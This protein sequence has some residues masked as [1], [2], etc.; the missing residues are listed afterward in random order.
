MKD[1]LNLKKN[2][3]SICLKDNKLE[4]QS[5]KKLDL[6]NLKDKIFKKFKIKQNDIVFNLVK[7]KENIN[8]KQIL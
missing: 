3:T 1:F 4:I 2:I 6:E 8:F 5:I 7:R